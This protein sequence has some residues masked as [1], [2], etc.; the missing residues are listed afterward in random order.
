[1]A[2][3]GV[4]AVGCGPSLKPCADFEGLAKVGMSRE[5]AVAALGEPN[6]SGKGLAGDYMNYTCGSGE[7]VSLILQRDKVARITKI[8]KSP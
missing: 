6:E 7:Q 3:A 1:M 5:E 8:A 4:V 2:F